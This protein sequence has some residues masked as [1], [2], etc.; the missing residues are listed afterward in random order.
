MTESQPR[1]RAVVAVAVGGGAAWFAG[2]SALAIAAPSGAT[3]TIAAASDLRYALDELLL[4]H[5]SQHPG[6][7]VEVVYGSSGKLSTQLRNGA[8]FELFFSADRAYTQPLFDAGLTTQA[9]QVYALGRLVLAS[10]D[11]ALARLPLGLLIRHPALQRFA[12]ANPAHAPYGQRARQVLQHLGLWDAVTSRLVLGDNVTQ[13]AQFIDSGAA[14]AGIVARSLVVAPALQGRL[15][16]ADIGSD[17]HA[18]LEQS[19]VLMKRGSAAAQQLALQ[20]LRLLGSESGQAL[21]L[22]HGFELPAPAPRR[23]PP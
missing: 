12:I 7:R 8:P 14:Q 11:P 2:S 16:W 15:A 20:L 17:A 18:P 22:R 10:R 1:R 13:A 4:T 21:M 3:L 5:R 9:P 19:W 6:A 23:L